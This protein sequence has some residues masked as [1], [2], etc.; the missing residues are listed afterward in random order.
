MKLII[1]SIISILNGLSEI[2][3]Y[4]PK[5]YYE[6]ENNI[7]LKSINEKN[8]IIDEIINQQNDKAHSLTNDSSSNEYRVTYTFQKQ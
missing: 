7:E 4:K 2:I 8:K 1:I 5:D 3:V 6:N